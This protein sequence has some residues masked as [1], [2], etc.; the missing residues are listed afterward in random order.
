M[1]YCDLSFSYI[2]SDVVGV[3]CIY[4]IEYINIFCEIMLWFIHIMWKKF[5]AIVSCVCLL[6]VM[7]YNKQSRYMLIAIDR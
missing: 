3:I 4:F 7:G 6:F 2:L 1:V 5:W